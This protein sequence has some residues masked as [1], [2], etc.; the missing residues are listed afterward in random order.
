MSV[1]FSAD[2]NT[3]LYG[4]PF[5]YLKDLTT[6][7]IT[8]TFPVPETEVEELLKYMQMRE[9]E[10]ESFAG[11]CRASLSP[12][13]KRL[14]LLSENGSGEIWVVPSH[15]R[16]CRLNVP[17]SEPPLEGDS[18][19]MSNFASF[20][21][22]GQILARTFGAV[23]EMWD[24]KSGV[25]TKTLRHGSLIVGACFAPDGQ[26]F[27]ILGQS[28]NIWDI[29][30]GEL[31][32]KIQL[33]QIYNMSICYTPDGKTLVVGGVSVQLWNVATG[34]CE[35]SFEGHR[36]AVACVAVSPDGQ[37]LASADGSGEVRLWDLR[38]EVCERSFEGHT[39]LI[40]GVCFSNDGRLLVTGSQNGT[41]MVWNVAAGHCQKLLPPTEPQERLRVLCLS[42]DNR[43]LAGSDQKIV[44]L[45]DLVSGEYKIL[46]EEAEGVTAGG[47][48]FSAN[49]K[50][51]A[52]FCYE[53][54]G[55]TIKIWDFTSQT[56]VSTHPMSE[57]DT[58]TFPDGSRAIP[59]WVAGSD[60]MPTSGPNTAGSSGSSIFI[61][62]T[63]PDDATPMIVWASDPR[64][65]C[66]SEGKFD[67]AENIKPEHAALLLQ[68]QPPAANN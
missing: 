18:V 64:A 53:Y 5:F 24:V 6:N 47:L 61:L 38:A 28:V 29:G 41:G 16:E 26:T 63:M 65:F 2:G 50:H 36:D 52:S 7:T 11:F 1:S 25:C 48:C 35:R 59:A 57:R 54:T 45:W 46:S 40:D 55:G 32:K 10:G 58:L 31:F 19:L 66:F 9:D 21:P 44:K 27:A 62:R 33:N 17:D 42:P 68:N 22:D 30:T 12:D 43:I 39:Q 15:E 20:S 60:A 23:V 37:T 56:L 49:G 13:G 3:L 51:L 4:A 8:A 67:G 14:A 34:V